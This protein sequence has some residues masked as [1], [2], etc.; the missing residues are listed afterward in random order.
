MYSGFTVVTIKSLL[1]FHNLLV[2]KIDRQSSVI[3][4][5]KIPLIKGIVLLTADEN[6]IEKFFVDV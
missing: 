2:I 4:K 3:T 5:A 1:C 6:G